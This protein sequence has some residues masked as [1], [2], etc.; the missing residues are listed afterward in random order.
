MQFFQ[1]P[2]I[3]TKW[4]RLIQ[5]LDQIKLAKLVN[6]FTDLLW[7]VVMPFHP[8]IEVS[9]IKETSHNHSLQ[10]THLPQLRALVTLLK[11]NLKQ[12][13]L[14]KMLKKPKRLLRRPPLKLNKR[15][16]PRKN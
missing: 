5:S 9:L 2:F 11:L 4:R 12:R 1:T 7:K 16:T 14:P 8:K 3:T 10:T 6:Q 15:R 13:V